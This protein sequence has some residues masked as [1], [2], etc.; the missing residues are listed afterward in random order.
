MYLYKIQ[1]E[2][3]KIFQRSVVYKLENDLYENRNVPLNF[4]K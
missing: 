4:H 3:A 1:R 2:E